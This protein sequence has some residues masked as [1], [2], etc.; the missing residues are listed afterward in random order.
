MA[1][2]ARG[3]IARIIGSSS[4]THQARSTGDPAPSAA[5]AE[6]DELARRRREYDCLAPRS[7]HEA[8]RGA[9]LSMQLNCWV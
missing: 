5:F 4:A 6:V 3:D 2:F 8:G 1:H 7:G 9:R